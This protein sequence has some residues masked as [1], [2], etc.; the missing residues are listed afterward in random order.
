MSRISAILIVS[1]LS[2][3][4]SPLAAASPL[5]VQPSI[6]SFVLRDDLPTASTCISR[7][8]RVLPLTQSSQHHR[9][10][11]PISPGRTV[12][13]SAELVRAR[14]MYP[15]IRTGIYAHTRTGNRHRVHERL[16]G[17]HILNPH[18]SVLFSIRSRLRTISVAAPLVPTYLSTEPWLSREVVIHAA[19]S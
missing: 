10:Y 17:N 3:I 4:L 9:P 18:I 1:L 16:S 2:A 6:T 19:V 15:H 8:A 11:R 7:A 13:G 5:T 14:H 12:T